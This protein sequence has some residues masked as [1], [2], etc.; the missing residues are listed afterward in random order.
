MQVLIGLEEELFLLNKMGFLS[1]FSEFLLHRLVRDLSRDRDRL[2]KA[3]SYLMGI[4]WEPNP[5]QIEYVTRPMEFSELREAVGFSR[6]LIARAAIRTNQL[7]YVGSVHPVESNPLPLN[8]THV[9]VSVSSN[10][11]PSNKL[12]AAIYMHIRNH[13]P[14]IIA[15]TANSPV[16]NGRVHGFGSARM[17]YSRVLKPSGPVMIRR[18]PVSFIP[19]RE[20]SK[21]RYGV[22]FRKMRLFKS[23]LVFDPA[24]DRLKEIAIRGPSTNIPEDIHTA[25]R[26]SRVEVRGIDNQATEEYLLDTALIIAGLAYEASV[27]VGRGVKIRERRNLQKNRNRA[28]K[29]GAEA[30]F[31]LDGGERVKARDS[32]ILMIDRIGE[33]IDLIGSMS[34]GLKEGIPEIIKIGIPEIVDQEKFSKLEERNRI[35]VKVRLSRERDGVSFTGSKFRASGEAKGLLFPEYSLKFR[36]ENG[37]VRKFNRI[38]K[39]YWLLSKEG[40]IP[41]VESDDVIKAITPVGHMA[42]VIERLGEA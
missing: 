23:E 37:I 36:E 13:L 5:S 40:Y 28:I 10:G 32:F 11:V 29:H 31:I 9:N 16:I 17:I 20:R 15:M 4:Q 6:R 12:L 27:L 42:K 19:W 41:L 1:R 39:R 22:I 21:T 30:E 35:V 8:G 38:E 34:S 3:R 26:S 25:K 2:E 33:Y 18:R 14:E 7:I 24:G